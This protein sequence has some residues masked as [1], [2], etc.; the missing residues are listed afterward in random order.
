MK[1]GG[2]SRGHLLLL[3]K[4]PVDNE[5]DRVSVP[6]LGLTRELPAGRKLSLRLPI[7]PRGGGAEVQT[8]HVAF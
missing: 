5:P 8:I 1:H 2:Y 4:D 6:N 7:A 3:F